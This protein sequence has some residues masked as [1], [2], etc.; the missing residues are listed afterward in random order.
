[1]PIFGDALPRREHQRRASRQRTI[2]HE[3]LVRRRGL[4]EA[5][6]FVDFGF[7]LTSNHTEG[8]DMFIGRLREPVEMI[9][10]SF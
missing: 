9:E 2:G 8:I 4:P 7:H 1:M 5:V 6:Q 10:L 3:L